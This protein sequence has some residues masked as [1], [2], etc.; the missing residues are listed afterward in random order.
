M[1]DAFDPGGNF[2]KD[3]TPTSHKRF[4]FNVNNVKNA[5]NIKDKKKSTNFNQTNGGD[6]VRQCNLN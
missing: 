4:D 2:E 6:E 3:L 5:K 1:G